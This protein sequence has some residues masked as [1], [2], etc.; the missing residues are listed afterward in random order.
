MG[1]LVVPLAI[2]LWNR[3]PGRTVQVGS[4]RWLEAGA[5]RRLRKL[6]PEQL[7]LFLLRVA[8]LALL[9]LAGPVWQRPARPQ[10]GPVLISPELLTSRGVEAVRPQIDSLRRQGHSLRLLQRGF[11]L[12]PAA[13]WLR[14]DSAY[15][16]SRKPQPVD[17]L[18]A[19]LQQATDSF[20]QGRLWAFTSVRLRN[21]QGGRPALPR[22][23]AWTAVPLDDSVTWV[24]AAFRPSPTTLTLLLGRSA[25]NRTTFRTITRPVSSQPIA[26][27][28]LGNW[29][30]QA[31]ADRALLVS[32]TD[33]IPVRT[34]AWHV[35]VRAAPSY[36]EEARHMRA[37]L[38][39]AAL[40]VAM[41][42]Q[43]TVSADVPPPAKPLDWVF[44]LTDEPL[45]AQLQA[46][47]ATGLH[48]WQVAAGPGK[49]ATTHFAPFPEG[50][51]VSIQRRGEAAAPDGSLALW[52][53]ATG[54]PLLSYTP[55][56]KGGYY[57]LHTRLQAGWSELGE[58]AELPALLLPLLSPNPTLLPAHDYRAL[59]A[60]PLQRFAD[61][62][63]SAQPVM[64][65]SPVALDLRVWWIL[66]AGIVWAIERLVAS[67]QA[68]LSAVKA[69]AV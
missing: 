18:W 5:N 23:L 37:A 68:R 38:R 3:R 16:A 66:A 41:P 52:A 2:Y 35:W 58:T 13:A 1:A 62:P 61:T 19:R 56:Q 46:R 67:R 12:V 4:L 64:A 53:D 25:E 63:P 36:T 59:P 11:P 55:A 24:Q 17:N 54:R 27:P 34:D 45:P 21:F 8:V 33:T 7:L 26:V 10:R 15:P 47:M 65:K 50:P 9:A 51:V 44:W 29:Q 43:L 40:G 32:A 69:S 22:R 42:L 60:A 14:P 48:I 6:S 57:Q 30:Y 49:V 28:G 31:S 39:A 20:P